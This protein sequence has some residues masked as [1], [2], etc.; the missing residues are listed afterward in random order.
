ME[1]RFKRCEPAVQLKSQETISK[2]ASYVFMNVATCS[3]E[4]TKKTPI[5][6][7]GL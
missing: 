7:K 3:R 5:I 2:T 4:L 1:H 6:Q